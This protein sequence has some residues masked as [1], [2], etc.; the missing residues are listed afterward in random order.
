MPRGKHAKRKLFAPPKKIVRKP[1]NTYGTGSLSAIAATVAGTKYVPARA[2][3]ALLK[4]HTKNPQVK[5]NVF[6]APRVPLPLT[7]RAPKTLRKTTHGRLEL[8]SRGYIVNK[9]KKRKP[10][11]NP[12]V[13]KK[14]VPKP[15]VVGKTT[16]AKNMHK[17]TRVMGTARERE[18]RNAL[19][20]ELGIPIPKSKRTS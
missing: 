16:N 12:S 17:T 6:T 3:S 9:S 18:I 7:N 13:A 11:I 14:M 5:Y 4:N 20:R 10:L 8:K 1:K 2:P 19:Y 15:R